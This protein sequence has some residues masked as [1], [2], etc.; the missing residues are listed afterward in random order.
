MSTKNN[1]R[2][3]SAED[4]Q[5]KLFDED[6]RNKK[7]RKLS[8]NKQ[9]RQTKE[10][11]EVQQSK[12]VEK[13]QEE[14]KEN[15]DN[16]RIPLKKIRKR[17]KGTKKKRTKALQLQNATTTKMDKDED[18]E[19]INGVNELTISA[20]GFRYGISQLAVIQKLKGFSAIEAIG[21]DQ[22]GNTVLLRWDGGFTQQ[23]DYVKIPSINTITFPDDAVSRDK[24]PKWSITSSKKTIR[25]PS[26]T[27]LILKGELEKKIQI[28]FISNWDE[29]GEIKEG[30]EMNLLLKTSNNVNI[31]TSAVKTGKVCA[32]IRK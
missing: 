5:K 29:L 17:R 28:N 7:K 16:N 23:G 8:V 18:I 9:V 25:N 3:Q 26:I 13:E 30:K 21:L 12:N 4:K 32:Q 22:N 24:I 31:N 14:E 20:N 10:V 11:A 2:K 6:P 19:W 15:T 27:Q 1:K